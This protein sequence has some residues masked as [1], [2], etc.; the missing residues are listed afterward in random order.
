[1]VIRMEQIPVLECRNVSFCYPTQTRQ[2]ISDISFRIQESEFVVL[3]GQS[4]CGKTTL[5]R[6]LKKNQIPFGSGSGELLFRGSDIE[7][8]DDR[9]SACRIGYVGQNPDTQIVTDK[10]WHELAFGLE[11]LGV[12]TAQIRKRTAELAQYFGME[13]WFH[14]PTAKLSG[15]QKQILNLAAVMVM[16]PEVLLLDEPTSQ[17]DPIGSQ[18]FLDTLQRLHRDFGTA[19]LL[20]EQRLE[21]V[22][23][24]ADH[25]LIMHQGRLVGDVPPAGCAKVLA[26]YRDDHGEDL[27]ISSAMPVAVRVWEQF[28]ADQEE[29]EPPVSIRQG[30]QWLREKVS[31][32]C[33][34]GAEGLLPGQQDVRQAGTSPSPAV[35]EAGAGPSAVALEV[36][37][38]SFQYEKG[39][40]VL[41]DFTLK[42]ARGSIYAILGGNGS[43]KSTALKAVMGI[44]KAGRG[45]VKAEGRMLYLAQNPRSL[46]T[47]LTVEEELLEVFEHGGERVSAEERAKRVREMISYLELQG[48]QEQNPMDLSGGQQQRLAMGKL[49]LLKP[50]ILLL[51]EP[52]KGLDSA[53]KQKLAKLLQNLCEEGRTIVLVSHDME[54]CASYAT[55]CGLL[56]DG[57]LA[58]TGTCREFFEDN[59]FYT[60]SASRMS[61]GILEGCILGEDIVKCLGK[62]M[63]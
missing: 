46:F 35:L 50:D 18:R 40:R 13:S 32:R 11:N 37:N 52:T 6:H 54:F 20:S 42:V 51:D 44:L 58:C 2:A 5:L 60:T 30:K 38:L 24:L 27:P 61:K 15:G 25:V 8:M 7:G 26:Q 36:K 9:E 34:E 1:M 53:F 29:T 39:Q 49:L 4:G 16:Q 14:R 41:D 33:R 59:E 23:P 55:H 10:V 31:E 45:K 47:E 43:G 56:F 21:E 57:A 28:G 22:I 48:Q 3:C 19:V 63:S 62:T 17:L 12:P